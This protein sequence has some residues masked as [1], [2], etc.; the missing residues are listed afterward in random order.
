M[1][2]LSIILTLALK[3]AKKTFKSKKY[4]FKT[5]LQYSKRTFTQP[6]RQ[7]ERKTESLNL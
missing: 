4:P 7:R 1:N 6:F 2:I 3:I 5:E